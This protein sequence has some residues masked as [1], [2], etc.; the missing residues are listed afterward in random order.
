MRSLAV[1]TA[2]GLTLAVSYGGAD[3]QSPIDEIVAIASKSKCSSVGPKAY[4][5]GMATVFARA[6]CQPFRDD[7][8]VVSAARG[9]PGTSADRTDALTWYDAKFT[10]LSMPNDKDG[11]DTLRHAYTLLVDLGLKESSGRYCLGRYLK[12]PF[13]TAESAEAGLFQASWGANKSHWSLAPM[14]H[15]YATD[16]SRCLL[17][18]FSRNISCHAKEAINWGEGIGAEW[19]KLTKVCPAFATEYAAVVLRKS[20]GSKGEFGPLRKKKVEIFTAC[21]TMFARVQALI[22]TKPEIC[23]ALR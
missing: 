13:N 6:V 23:G 10:N 9:V 20:G 14:Y 8:K 16:P 1:A 11:V 15:R 17:P 5:N 19:Q 3:A 2:I 18:V 7:V 21:D 4:I 12:D 22:Q